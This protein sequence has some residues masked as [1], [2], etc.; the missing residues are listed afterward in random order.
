MVRDK[1]SHESKGS[2]FVWYRTRADA[3]R[4][5]LQLN[6]RHVLPNSAGEPERP[7]VVRRANTRK[8]AA[9]LAFGAFATQ[10]QQ[11]QQL[12]HHQV[13]VQVQQHLQHLQH[14]Q[15][16]H[17]Q[18]QMHLSSGSGHAMLADPSQQ[19]AFMGPGASGLQMQQQHQ[20]PA[21]V[22]QQQPGPGGS[23]NALPMVYSMLPPGAAGPD[24]HQT[25]YAVF[26]SDGG[27]GL[28]AGECVAQPVVSGSTNVINSAGM[29]GGSTLVS[30]SGNVVS[31][32]NSTLLSGT[33]TG[34]LPPPAGAPGGGAFQRGR[35]GSFT[36][37]RG[38]GPSGGGGGGPGGAGGG[39]LVVL[40]IPLV[41]DQ[42]AAITNHIFSIQMMSNADVTCQA[43]G[44][45]VFCLVLQG[46]KMQVEMANHMVASVLHNLQ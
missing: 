22:L 24:G 34:L 27:G 25:R 44:P 2:A 36:A 46:G 26:S 11:Q 28:L 15:M 18:Q 38:A 32:A 12:P 5:C 30:T 4:A 3:D 33:N 39:P 1:V 14:Q 42:M 19:M 21:M 6:V 17:Q 9:P 29:S 13:Q 40:Q 10:Q 8:P 7:L 23:G 35:G 16:Q 20:H 41:A 37:D 43:V 31:G 45:G